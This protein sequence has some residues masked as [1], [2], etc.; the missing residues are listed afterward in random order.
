MD[1]GNANV[2]V[3][4]RL[5]SSVANIV[6]PKKAQVNKRRVKVYMLYIFYIRYMLLLFYNEF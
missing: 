3:V 4:T 2:I 6:S 5:D 1:S